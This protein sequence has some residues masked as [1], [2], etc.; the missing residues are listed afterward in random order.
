MIVHKPMLFLF[1][2]QCAWM[3][4]SFSNNELITSSERVPSNSIRLHTTKI[5][6]YDTRYD[7]PSNLSHSTLLS[8]LVSWELD[9]SKSALWRYPQ[10]R[11]PILIFLYKLD[12]SEM[13]EKQHLYDPPVFLDFSIG[14]KA[15]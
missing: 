7:F 1:V 15:I 4:L 12:F 5:V 2:K 10:Y 8:D 11:Q 6:W 3:I 14:I 9:D 13:Y